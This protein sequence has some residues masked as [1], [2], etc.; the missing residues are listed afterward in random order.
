MQ[1]MDVKRSNI[2]SSVCNSTDKF[3]ISLKMTEDFQIQI[4]FFPPSILNAED[5]RK[6]SCVTEFGTDSNF[7][8]HLSCTHLQW[9]N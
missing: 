8:N 3:Y 1:N 6:G 2:F 5:I 7:L 9:V 4:S